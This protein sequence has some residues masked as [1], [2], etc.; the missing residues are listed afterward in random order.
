ML[1]FGAFGMQIV[2]RFEIVAG[3]V[4]GKEVILSYCLL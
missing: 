2:E 1:G 3:A 4:K